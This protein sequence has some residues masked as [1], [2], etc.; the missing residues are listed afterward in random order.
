MLIGSTGTLFVG[1]D[2]YPLQVVEKVNDSTFV[3]VHL[4]SKNGKGIENHCWLSKAKDSNLQMP[5]VEI[6]RKKRDG[7]WQSKSRGHFIEGDAVAYSDPSF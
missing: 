7:S 6:L 2:R 1:T 3:A 4:D 5:W